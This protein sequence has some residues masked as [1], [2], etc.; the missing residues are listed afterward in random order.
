MMFTLSVE[1]YGNAY[2]ELYRFDCNLIVSGVAL[3]IGIVLCRK[4]NKDKNWHKA[5]FPMSYGNLSCSLT[6]FQFIKANKQ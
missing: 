6:W 4:Y 5:R 2:I 1:H 3:I